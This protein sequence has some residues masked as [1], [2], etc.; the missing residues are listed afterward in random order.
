MGVDGQRH[1]WADLRPPK[2]AVLIVQ[3][4]GLYNQGSSPRGSI[5]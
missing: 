2:G 3:S 5:E 1:A 4:Q